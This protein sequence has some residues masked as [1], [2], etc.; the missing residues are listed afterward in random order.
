MSMRIC[1]I[2][3]GD[4]GTPTGGYLYHRRIAERAPQYE[5][6]LSFLSFPTWPFPSPAAAGRSVS[7]QARDADVIVLDSI[8]ASFMWPWV[9]IVDGTPIVAILHQPP[10]GIDHARIRTRIQAALDRSVYRRAAHVMVASEP[11]ASELVDQGFPPEELTVVP[12]GRDVAAPPEE[13]APLR[14]D[15]GLAFLSVGNWI[16]RKGLLELLEAF[17]AL[18][19]SIGV[20]HLAGDAGRGAYS[21]RV[22][23][24]IGRSDLRGRIE[25]H[26]LVTRE[27]VAELYAGAD[28]FVLPSLKEPYGTVYGEAMLFGLPVVG[29]DAGNLPHLARHGREGLILPP[30]DI[31]ALREA[32]LSV[33]TNAGLRHELSESARERASHLPTWDE[34]AAFFFG[35]CRRYE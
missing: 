1:L 30:G 11:L 23:E 3:Q 21:R 32:L 9:R 18:P 27:R 19:R 10:G 26:G 24:R 16:A 28:V 34:V 8:A 29:W 31:G 17:A 15:G 14:K 5:V 20:L 35:V 4:P 7:R 2:T 6:E 13:P 25:V 33:A 22:K 12:P